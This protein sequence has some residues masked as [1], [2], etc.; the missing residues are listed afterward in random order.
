MTKSVPGRNWPISLAVL[1]IEEC[2]AIA[3]FPLATSRSSH[4][5]IMFSAR[6]ARAAA[7]DGEHERDA[8]DRAVLDALRARG[9]HDRDAARLEVEH[10]EPL[11]VAHQRL[12]AGA[13]GEAHLD[14]A[15]GVRRAEECLRPGRV[16]AVDEDRLGAVDRERLRVG[17]EAAD[18][19]LEV[20]AL[21]DRALGHHA[22]A[23]GLRADE[24]RDRVQRRVAGDAD[25]RLDLGEAR[26]PPPRRR[27]RRAAPGSPSGSSR[28]PGCPE[29]GGRGASSARTSA[30]R[31]RA[32]PRRGRASPG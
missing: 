31:G 20:A 16:V 24:E 6:I 25:G 10:R 29:P 7:R 28:A 3:S 23:P 13:G 32:F 30:R 18:R 14:A 17:D 4:A 8:R 1:R 27:R 19:E 5:A 12:G 22:R 2:E 21:L 11:R 15:R 26:A 9:A